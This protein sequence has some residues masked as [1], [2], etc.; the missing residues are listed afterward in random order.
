MVVRADQDFRMLFEMLHF[1]NV[2]FGRVGIQ[3]A[4]ATDAS[5]ANPF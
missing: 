3:A 2:D 1:L 5:K 4:F